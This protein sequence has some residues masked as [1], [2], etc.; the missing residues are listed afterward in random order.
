[1]SGRTTRTPRLVAV[2][3]GQRLAL[4]ERAAAPPPGTPDRKDLEEATRALLKRFE[5]LQAAFYA[6]GRKAL[7]L[8]QGRDDSHR[9]WCL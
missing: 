9:G 7:L 3:A 5:A 2:T 1:V 4:G 6:D 8:R